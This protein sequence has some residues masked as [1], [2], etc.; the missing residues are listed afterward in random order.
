[1]SCPTGSERSRRRWTCWSIPEWGSRPHRRIFVHYADGR[2]VD[3]VVQ[4]ASAVSGRVPG[5]VVL[6]DPDG[7][8][9]EQRVPG[10]AAATA[11][12]VREW[13]LLAWE[14]LADAG[15]YLERRSPWEALARLT[16]ARDLALRLWAVA[17]DVP[18]PLFGLTSL[19][20]ADPPRLP[21]GLEA[22]VA[23]ADL[24]E[25]SVATRACTELL[26]EASARARGRIGSNDA[27]SPMAAWDGER[28]R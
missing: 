18:Y 26:R 17:E 19:L 25:L 2:Q 21:T 10:V 11:E 3:L 27:E 16:Q 9:A 14:S 12:D 8:L 1:M 22:T 24:D 23:R 15:K 6:Y 7:R 13:E 20:D 28:L 4:P 5:A